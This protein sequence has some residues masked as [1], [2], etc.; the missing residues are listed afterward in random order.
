[1]DS[2][3]PSVGEK[4]DQLQDKVNQIN[5]HLNQK[6]DHQ[7]ANSLQ[8]NSVMPVIFSVL[9]LI[10]VILGVILTFTDK[11]KSR[12]TKITGLPFSQSK[13]AIKIIN[14]YNIIEYEKMVPYVL[15]GLRLS[16]KSN[17]IKGVILRINSGGG[18]VG[19]SQE[20]YRRILQF[21]ADL[22]KMRKANPSAEIKPVVAVMG[23][24]AASGAYYIACSTDRIIARP[25]TLTGSIGVIMNSFTFKKLFDKVG[26]KQEIVKSGK[27][28]AIGS[29]I[30]R[31]RRPE[32]TE[33][34]QDIVDETYKQFFNAVLNG[35]NAV[36]A[37]DKRIDKD[38]LRRYADGRI[39]N[40]EFARKIRLI[41]QLGGLEEG[42]EQI[43]ALYQKMNGKKLGPLTL[44]E[45]DKSPF[46]Q[47]IRLLGARSHAPLSVT[48][49]IKNYSQGVPLYLYTGWKGQ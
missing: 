38:L 43:K 9:L 23:D 44:I 3:D 42:V 39:F 29:A 32:E 6:S 18:T 41:D 20:I 8:V 15:S 17:N 11:E 25:G 2:T 36:L 40:G 35:R 14:I 19:A 26:I 4:L 7:N 22:R 16:Q 5:Q 12:S 10:S 30:G 37:K 31:D 24:I 33:L 46:M 47:L 34:L 45:D 48:D 13:D 27:F 21:K 1:M 28:K 49:F